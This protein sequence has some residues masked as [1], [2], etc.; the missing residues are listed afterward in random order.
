MT[1]L[2]TRQIACTYLYCSL[3]LQ[4]VKDAVS[5]EPGNHKVDALEWINSGDDGFAALNTACE[6]LAGVS[7]ALGMTGP[8]SSLP[9]TPEEW[10]AVVNDA[11]NGG[12]PA[13]IAKLSETFER[14]TK[15]LSEAHDLESTDNELSE[16]APYYTPPS[17]PNF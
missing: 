16:K 8:E 7:H 13:A 15:P 2:T 10:L 3:T 12:S 11:V 6:H 1:S 5:N 17:S 4:A 9:T 14:L